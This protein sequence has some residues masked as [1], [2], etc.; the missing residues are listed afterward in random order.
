[1]RQVWVAHQNDMIVHVNC[2]GLK[3]FDTCSSCQ[4]T[5]NDSPYQK[6]LCHFSDFKMVVI[7]PD[8]M[9][10]AHNRVIHPMENTRAI[11]IT[12]DN[13]KYRVEGNYEGIVFPGNFILKIKEP[14]T[15]G[16][17]GMCRSNFCF[18]EQC[19]KGWKAWTPKKE[20]EF[21]RLD[22]AQDIYY[23]EKA[24]PL[25]R[26]REQEVSV[27]IKKWTVKGEEIVTL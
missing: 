20:Q 2:D 1:M 7:C 15:I 13:G 11:Y 3:Q 26:G 12:W 10:K 21:T 17:G 5:L 23:E 24:D 6:F 19:Q 25:M 16:L 14:T 18:L 22:V 27:S 9:D 4:S 8:C